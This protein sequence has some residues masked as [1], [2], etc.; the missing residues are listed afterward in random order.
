MKTKS[1][2]PAPL[3][4]NEDLGSNMNVYEASLEKHTSHDV[5]TRLNMTTAYGAGARNMRDI[6]EPALSKMRSERDEL[7]GA[8][9]RLLVRFEEAT[10]ERPHAYCGCTYCEST[11]LLSKYKTE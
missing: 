1:P 2:A 11:A 7:V 6:Y 4:S 3:V 5:V 9:K 10:G 8:Y